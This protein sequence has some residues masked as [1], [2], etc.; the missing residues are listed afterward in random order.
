MFH[1]RIRIFS[2][3][4]VPLFLAF[5]VPSVAGTKSY[6]IN[7][8]LNEP[9][10]FAIQGRTQSASPAYNMPVPVRQIRP[11]ARMPGSS[12]RQPPRPAA[13]RTASQR[14][15]LLTAQ[16]MANP[17]FYE[18][19]TGWGILSE[20]RLG[21]LVHDEGPFSRN[22]EDGVD[23][24]FELLFKSPD[25]MSWAWSP[26]P[27]IGGSINSNGDTSQLYAGL[28]WEWDFWRSWFV[29]FSLGGALHN[30]K[31]T[32]DRID[33]K[34][35]GC[36]L[37][38]RESIELGYRINKTYSIT[39]FLDHVSNGNLCTKNEGLESFGIRYGYRF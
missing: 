3:V 23:G 29:D 14:I 19:R 32:T 12:Y 26:R 1:S 13:S 9:H 8:L 20:A 31:K 33:R 24:N 18:D 34:E 7:V 4:I 22:E 37:L 2:G 25:F 30:G 10:P 35:L 36:K 27:H 6:D 11:P 21:I 38:F 16:S 5:T 15:P 28:T 17:T 39:A